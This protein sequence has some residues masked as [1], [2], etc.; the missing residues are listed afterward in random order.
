MGPEAKPMKIIFFGG[1][2]RRIVR[3]DCADLTKM[4][5]S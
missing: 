1:F 4:P 3:R 2:W 5:R